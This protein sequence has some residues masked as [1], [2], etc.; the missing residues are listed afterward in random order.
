MNTVR[1][2]QSKTRAANTCSARLLLLRTIGALLWLSLLVFPQTRLASAQE[3]GKQVLVLYSTRRDGELTVIGDREIAGLIS[4]G[5]RRPIDYYA[6]YLDLPRSSDPAYQKSIRDFLDIK[7]R[8][9][10]FDLIIAVQDVAVDFASH[11]RDDLYPNTPV[12]YLGQE[13]VVPRLRNS[14]GFVSQPDLASTVSF[15]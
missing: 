3:K 1:R 8:N 6:E 9:Q 14:T 11:Y 4:T 12:I 5:L 13:A 10:R 15:A 7:Y 2:N